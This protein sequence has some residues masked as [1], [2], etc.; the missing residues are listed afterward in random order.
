M[1][2]SKT[3]S[4]CKSKQINEMEWSWE[5]GR[6][7]PVEHAGYTRINKDQRNNHQQRVEPTWFIS[8]RH[9][10]PQVTPAVESQRE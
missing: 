8:L 2:E 1:N 10:S 5:A 6:K 3:E 9:Q 4:P 7:C